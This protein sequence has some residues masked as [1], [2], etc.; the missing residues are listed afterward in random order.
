VYWPTTEPA[1][2][3]SASSK[4]NFPV[5]VSN[6]LVSLNAEEAIGIAPWPCPSSDPVV[7]LV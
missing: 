5:V 6:G 7:V 4:V 2:K 3:M 1:S